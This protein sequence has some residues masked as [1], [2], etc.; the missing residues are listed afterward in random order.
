MEIAFSAAA[1]AT[2]RGSLRCSFGT[3]RRPALARAS[4]G[5]GVSLP[6]PS[7]PARSSPLLRPFGDCADGAT[8]A[9]AA[10]C[11]RL[12]SRPPFSASEEADE[13]VSIPPL[14][15]LG[16]AVLVAPDSSGGAGASGTN[17]SGLG[18]RRPTKT[19]PLLLLRPR[20][21]TAAL[22]DDDDNASFG[23]GAGGARPSPSRP[24]PSPSSTAAGPPIASSAAASI[25]LSTTEL[26]TT[27]PR[28]AVRLFSIESSRLAASD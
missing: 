9:I 26:S 1:A 15:V 10:A 24:T 16:W 14:E 8:P 23:R 5:D 18:D 11:A 21:S 25:G 17:D 20:C 28:S 27:T 4:V 22:R 12:L 3:L 2:S 13:T 6:P 19:P 7:G